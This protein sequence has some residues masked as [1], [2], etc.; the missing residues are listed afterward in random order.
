MSGPSSPI[1]AIRTSPHL[2]RGSRVDWIMLQVLIALSPALVFAACAF[3][4]AAMLVIGVSVIACLA[5]EALWSG[6]SGRTLR[7]GSALVTAVLYA[8]TLPPGLPL[9]MVAVGGVVSIWLGKAIFGGLGCN[10]FN[11]ALVGRAFLQAAFPSAMT[12]WLPSFS[13]GRFS[14]VPE[15][16]LALPFLRPVYDARTS[17]TPLAAWKFDAE[18]TDSMDLLL[19][20]TSGSL[21]E[22]SSALLLLGGLYLIARNVMSWRVPVSIGISVALVSGLLRWA[23]PQSY[24]SPVFMLFS[25]GLM[26]GSLFMAT[27]LVGSPMTSRGCW[28]YGALIGVLVVSIRAF[29]GMPEGVMYAILLANATTP[30]IDQWIRPRPFGAP[31]G[32][33]A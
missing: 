13:V 17:A 15:S 32:A 4:A 31:G 33:R 9:W 29:G 8:L 12:N 27:D 23:D 6:S 7:D 10:P 5:M 20:L 11:P 30:L 16:T 22:T 24:A 26:L 14:S 25:G 1:L 3:G 19:G 21:G 2:V 28:L 18:T